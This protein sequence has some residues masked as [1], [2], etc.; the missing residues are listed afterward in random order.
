M[1]WLLFDLVYFGLVISFRVECHWLGGVP[2]GSEL[3][4]RCRF[5]TRTGCCHMH[6][7]FLQKSFETVSSGSK[8]RQKVKRVCILLACF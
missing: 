4:T 2:V 6:G 7:D 8:Q 3:Q 5:I 1:G